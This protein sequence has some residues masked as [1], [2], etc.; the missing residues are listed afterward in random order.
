MERFTNLRVIIYPIFEKKNTFGT[1]RAFSI[2][3]RNPIECLIWQ[4]S[5][6]LTTLNPPSLNSAPSDNTTLERLNHSVVNLT[7]INAAYLHTIIWAMLK[8][9]CELRIINK[10]TLVSLHPRINLSP[11][12]KDFRGEEQY[13]ESI[14]I[15]LYAL[16]M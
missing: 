4:H 8:T 10:L 11:F 15:F 5:I 6:R 7:Q 3:A 12:T 9:W 13:N 1:D 16:L 2:I 14:E